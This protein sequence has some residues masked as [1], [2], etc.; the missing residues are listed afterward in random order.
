MRITTSSA[1]LA[2]GM[3]AVLAFSLSLPMTRLAVAAID[4]VWLA[5]ARGVGAAAIAIIV[6]AASGSP[7]PARADWPDL[8]AVAAGVVL[9]FPMTTSIA[10]R[11]AGAAHGAVVIAILPLAT[12]AVGALLTRTR[13][14]LAFW[15]LAVVGA[16]LVVAHTRLT[17]GTLTGDA[18]SNAWLALAIAS[19]ATGYAAGGRLAPRLGGWRTICWGL[20]IAGPMMAPALAWISFRDGLPA[21]GVAAWT[22]FAYV[23]V[24]SQLLGFF[25]WYGAMAAAG[26]ARVS[27]LQLAQVFL[28]IGFAAW[29]NDEPIAPST[30]LFAAMVLGVVI[31]S[32]RLPYARPR[33]PSTIPGRT[34]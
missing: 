20:A 13:L 16:A 23:T 7:L 1:G 17:T 11:D 25:L 15:L 22:G 6:L 24:V 26:I 5:L 19:A 8:L 18:R 34:L 4:P 3:A 28:T 12:A 14:P 10:M 2:A 33:Q 27:Q 30:W 32:Q 9:G 31:A 29:I 21:A